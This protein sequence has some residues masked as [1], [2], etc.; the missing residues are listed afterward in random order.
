MRLP[1]C[2]SAMLPDGVARNVGWAFSHT[3]APVVE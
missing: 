3:D 2:P 1:L